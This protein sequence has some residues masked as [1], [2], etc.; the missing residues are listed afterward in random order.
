MV[1]AP[2]PDTGSLRKANRVRLPGGQKS[3]SIELRFEGIDGRR[4]R[5]ILQSQQVPGDHERRRSR[6]LCE[7]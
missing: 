7:R 4:R 6:R 2:A 5:G 3:E 1:G